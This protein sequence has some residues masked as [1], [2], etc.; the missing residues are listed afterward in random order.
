MDTHFRVLYK[1]LYGHL[2]L[3]WMS[4]IWTPILESYM[5][6][7][8]WILESYMDTHFSNEFSNLFAATFCLN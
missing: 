6:S 5:K 7:L 1:V 3:I 4:L 2:S 8:I